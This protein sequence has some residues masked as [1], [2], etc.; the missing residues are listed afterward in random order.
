MSLYYG[1]N[2]ILKVFLN[3]KSYDLIMQSVVTVDN[4]N[5]LLSSDNYILTDLN[6]L[7]LTVKEDK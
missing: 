5:K 4:E 6:G 7:Y 3:N 2:K 1:S